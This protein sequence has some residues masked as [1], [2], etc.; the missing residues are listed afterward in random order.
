[1]SPYLQQH[2]HNPVDW[3]PWGE[4]AFAKAKKEDK[5][6]FLSIGYATCHWCHVMERESFS[7][8]E[9]AV[10]L[11]KNFVAIKVDR[12]ERPDVDKIY[13][14]AV[15]AMTGSGGWPLSVWLTPDRQPFFGGTYFPPDARWGRPGFPQILEKIAEAWRTD[16]QKIV[17]SGQALSQRLIEHLS[18]ESGVS[19]APEAAALDAGYKAFESSYDVARGGFSGAPKFPMPVNMNFMLRY[20]ARTEN[21]KAL[22]MTAHTLREMAKGGIYDQV[23]GGFHRYSTD[24]KW[25]VP[26]FEKMLYDNAQLAIN[27]V[28]A[29]QITKDEDFARVARETLDYVL[30]DMS[31]PEGGFYSA[32]DADSLPPELKGKI[33]DK[34]HEHKAEGAFYVWEKKEILQALG[35]ENGEIFSFQYGVKPEGNAESD[36]HGEF[37]D[38]NILY[39]AHSLE[40]TVRQFRKKPKDAA[41]ILEESRGKL[42]TVRAARPRPQKD[43]KILVSWNGLMISAYARASSV[44]DEARYLEAAEKAARFIQKNLYDAKAR[45]LYRRWREGERKVFGTADDY[46]FLVQGLLDLYEASFYPAW[47]AWAIELTEEQNKLFHDAEKGGFYMTAQDHDKALLARVKEDSDNVEPAAGSVAALN[48][49]RLAQYTD[50]DDFRTAAEKTLILY[51]AQAKEQPRSLPQMLAALDFYLSKPRQIVI[52]G[53]P[54]KDDTRELLKRVRQRYL[55]N[56][57]LIVV[58]DGPGRQALVRQMPF[59]KN[60]V[61][62][63]GKATAYV[64]VNYACDLPTADPAKLAKILEG[65]KQ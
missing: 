49:L 12:E 58:D 4:E 32:E 18:T 24:E 29:Y 10:L 37:K 48:L 35:T 54:E 56:K 38:K 16:R 62:I 40:E 60:I 45:R 33:L 57:I 59:L 28:E 15:Q 5:P 39:V 52:A 20:Y 42:L 14:T 1:K 9:T 46:A 51:S 8:P 26:H 19:Q 6:I 44:L 2:A 64:C 22:D 63:Q 36:P 53:S 3:Y 43:D 61:P 30:R 50:R 11:N 55:P 21:K 17:E 27:Y 7:S 65:A 25:H 13:M 31:R 41:R 34:G 47:L 23:G